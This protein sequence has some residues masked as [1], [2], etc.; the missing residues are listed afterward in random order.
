[1]VKKHANMSLIINAEKYNKKTL[2]NRWKNIVLSFVS[3]SKTRDIQNGIKQSHCQCTKTVRRKKKGGKRKKCAWYDHS[4][5]NRKTMREN[6]RPQKNGEKR[7]T[8]CTIPAPLPQ[9]KKKI[10]KSEEHDPKKKGEWEKK[11]CCHH[12]PKKK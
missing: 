7:M 4:M 9:K 12:F 10:S 8:Y 6:T 5:K 11:Y 1:M 3:L 2:E